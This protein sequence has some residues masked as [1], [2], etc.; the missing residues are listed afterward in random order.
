META[1][2]GPREAGG[3]AQERREGE[4]E[5]EEFVAIYVFCGCG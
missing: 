4:D 3:A 1:V 5:K 2:L